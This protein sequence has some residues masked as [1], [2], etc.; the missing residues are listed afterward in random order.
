MGN[1][2]GLLKNKKTGGYS[3]EREVRYPAVL[4]LRIHNKKMAKIKKIYFCPKCKLWRGS[5]KKCPECKRKTIPVDAP[6]K[7][8]SYYYIPGIPKPLPSV[9]TIL[10]DVLAKPALIHWV[11]ETAAKAALENPWMSVK[12]AVSSIYRTKEKAGLKGKDIHKIIQNLSKG[13]KVEK[14][15]EIKGYIEAYEKFK[16]DVPFRILATEK[17]VYSKK[18]GYAG[19]LDA[20]IK[21]KNGELAIIDFKTGKYVYREASIQLSAYKQALEEMYPKKKKPDKTFVVHLKSDGTYSLIEKNASFQIFLALK[22]VWLWQQSL[23]NNNGN[24]K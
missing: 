4:L 1:L 23:E 24:N 16:A 20:I 21:F 11:A 6:L 18:Y 7:R 5:E 15:K 22:K 19:T 9:T 2:K 13:G 14:T 3:E 12:E 8:G 17:I 10:N